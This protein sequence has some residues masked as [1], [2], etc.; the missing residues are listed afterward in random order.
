MIGTTNDP[1]TPYEWAV[2]LAEQLS[3]GV[4]LTRVGEGHTAYGQGNSCIDA[5]VDTFLLEGTP[6]ADQTTCK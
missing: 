1:A 3:S 6:P 5:A 4:L 2:S